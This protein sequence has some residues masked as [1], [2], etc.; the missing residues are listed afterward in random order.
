M[1][2]GGVSAE[3]LEKPKDIMLVD[4]ANGR[5]KCMT[6]SNSEIDRKPS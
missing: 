2:G 1:G 6:I 5:F 3:V 4:G